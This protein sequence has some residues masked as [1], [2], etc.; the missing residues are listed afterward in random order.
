MTAQEM[1]NEFLTRYDAA[2]SAASPGWEQS[3]ILEFLNIAQEKLIVELYTK[4]KIDLL[5]EITKDVKLQIT[6]H[7]SYPFSRVF[8]GLLPEDY[9]LYVNSRT[10]LV[11]EDLLHPETLTT[12]LRNNELIYH[13]QLTQFLQSAVNRTIF[14]N[15]KACLLQK[16]L[17][18]ISD[19]I[20]NIRDVFLTYVK[21]PRLISISPATSCELNIVLHKTV[22][23]LAVNEAITSVSN[24]K[25]KSQQ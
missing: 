5:N 17:M 2:A 21:K 7:P 15:P 11:I 3:E 22:V 1:V 9:M 25:L 20:S 19:S 10:V 24:T 4:N 6:A 23:E 13:T 14:R 16:S 12:E 18:V 8:V